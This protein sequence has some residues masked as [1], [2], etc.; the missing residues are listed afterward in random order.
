MQRTTPP[1]ASVAARAAVA[2]LTIRLV[3]EL[4]EADANLACSGLG[5]WAALAVLGSGATGTTAEE[6]GAAL[7]VRCPEE[8]A[9]TLAA[10]DHDV[11]SLG[12]T[13]HALA[14][15]SRVPTYRAWRDALPMIG[16]AHLDDDA[17]LDAWVR[18]HTDGIIDRVPVAIDDATLV[19]LVDALCLVTRWADPFPRHRTEPRPFHAPAGPV[20][21]PTMATLVPAERAGTWR[22]TTVVDVPAQPGDGGRVVLRLGLGVEGAAPPAVVAAVLEAGPDRRAPLPADRVDLYVPRF[23]VRS[24]HDLVP[25]L[26]S[27]GVRRVL[28]DDADLPLL[29]PERLKVSQA[30][31]EA[32]VE[33]DEE[34]VRAAAVTA[35]TLVRAAGWAQPPVVVPLHLDRPFAFALLAETTG[36]P[37]F[38]GWVADPLTG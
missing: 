9:P 19:A 33:V 13:A 29:S 6:L 24:H 17:D 14:L 15:W 37:L 18:D 2:R 1:S 30:V 4:A 21:V 8:A 31:Q 38:A 11:T 10:V 36:L 28:T 20:D 35:M 3:D 22:G 5:L 7:G 12:G 23:G 26:R 32:V 27:V 16:V 34:G 25:L